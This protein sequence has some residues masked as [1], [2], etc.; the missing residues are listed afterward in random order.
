M[1]QRIYIQN[2]LFIILFRKLG[3]I[4]NFRKQFDLFFQ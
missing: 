3:E 4:R 2:S 1:K